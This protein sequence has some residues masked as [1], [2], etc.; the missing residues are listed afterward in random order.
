M[1]LDLLTA[2][3]WQGLVLFVWVA[4]SVGSFLNVVIYRL[5]V[6]LERE[7]GEQARSILE[8]DAD[9]S[10]APD[11]TDTPDEQ[12]EP[13]N[14]MVPRSRCPK[15]SHQ[16]TALENIP[17]LS[18]LFLRGKCS[19]CKAPI[20]FRYPAIELATALTCLVVASLFGFTWFGLFALIFTWMLIA[21]TFIDY[22]TTLL[23]DQ[24]TYPLLWLGLIANGFFIGVVS[25]QDA[26][27][28]AIAGYLFLWGT[29]WAFKLITSKEGMGYG[30]FKLFAALGAWM[31]WQV[32]PSIILIAAGLGLIYALSR[33]FTARQSSQEPIPFGPFLAIAGWVTLIFRDTVL[34]VFSV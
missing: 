28:G 22:D 31:G 13:F 11:A 26:V 21:A 10:D 16:I 23:P 17:V 6:M 4:L 18:W 24:I 1:S 33:I 15:C 7:W 8:L 9:P 34:S 29:Y 19:G 32:L 20:S 2:Y 30:D 3:G 25:L 5:P 14:L 27:I 12:A